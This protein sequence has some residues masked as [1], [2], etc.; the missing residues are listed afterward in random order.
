[1]G[2]G[3]ARAPSPLSFI[4]DTDEAE[5]GLMVLF[6]GFVFSVAPLSL[7]IFLPKS[8]VLCRI[9]QALSLP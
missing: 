5:G 6:F 1:M 8:L 9:N 4:L 2:G 7:E 3:R